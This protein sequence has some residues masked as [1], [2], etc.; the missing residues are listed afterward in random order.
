MLASSL[1]IRNFRCDSIQPQR[2]P[3]FFGAQT[4]L[5]KQFWVCACFPGDLIFGGPSTCIINADTYLI[6]HLH[7]RGTP[8]L[9]QFC[10]HSASVNTGLLPAEGGVDFL[11]NSDLQGE[12]SF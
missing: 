8:S 2:R 4:W 12:R 5:F 7:H 9:H 3:L 1:H 11:L 10:S 6:K